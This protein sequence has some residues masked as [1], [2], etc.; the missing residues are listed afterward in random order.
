MIYRVFVIEEI[1]IPVPPN[2]F[3]DMAE[4]VVLGILNVIN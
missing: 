2:I 4:D 3:E 1:E